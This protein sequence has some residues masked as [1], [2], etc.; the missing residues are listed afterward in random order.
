MVLQY[1]RNATLDSTDLCS[2]KNM[3]FTD[4][5]IKNSLVLV[6]SEYAQCLDFISEMAKENDAYGIIVFNTDNAF[7][8]AVQPIDVNI[9][10]LFISLDYGTALKQR[11][12][13]GGNV[14]IKLS[15]T[16]D[17]SYLNQ[18]LVGGTVSTFSSIGPSAELLFKPEIAGVGGAILSTVPLKAGGWEISQGTSMASPYIAGSIGLYLAAHG[19]KAKENPSLIKTKFMNYAKPVSVYKSQSLDSPLRQGAGLVQGKLFI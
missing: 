8:G 19:K 14:R 13:D 12:Q 11:F 17:K 15:S 9:T 10:T 4:N 5:T 3:V 2:E 16:Q 18:N 7:S 1:Y 6:D